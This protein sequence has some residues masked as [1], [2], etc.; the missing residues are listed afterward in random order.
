MTDELFRLWVYLS[1]TPLA[2]LT[3]TLVAYAIG[4]AI[5]ARSSFHPIANP[6]PI[7]VA[8]VVAALAATR[9][10]Y[11]TYFEGAQFV[12][13][14]LRPAV[15]GLAVPLAREWRGVR[16]LAFPIAASLV[17]GSVVAATSAVAI[18]WALG[19]SPAT[20]ASLVPK[21]VT[22]PVAMGIA[23]RI[24]GLPALAAVFAVATGVV[25]AVLGRYVFD[26]AGVSDLR[27]RGFALGLAAHGIGTARAFQVDRDAGTYAGLAFGLHALAAAL[28]M[29]L[30][31]AAW[32]AL[33]G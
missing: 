8:V 19:V 25:G 30:A 9:T 23:E 32:R 20:L 10:P 18:A 12:H 33:A 14:L 27:A 13:F 7:A 21:S 26:A 3:L 11:R 29:P 16:R 4:Y 22:A 1:S 15:V 5:Y 6:V 31:V 24:G 17:V 28:A 2:G